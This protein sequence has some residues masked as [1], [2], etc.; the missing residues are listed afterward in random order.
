[1]VVATPLSKEAIPPVVESEYA[2]IEKQLKGRTKSQMEGVH[3]TVVAKIRRILEELGV[4]KCALKAQE[5]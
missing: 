4:Q 1:M 5:S 3:Q 2:D